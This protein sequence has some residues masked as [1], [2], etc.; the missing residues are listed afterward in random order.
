MKRKRDLQTYLSNLM[1][2]GMVG[3]PQPGNRFTD[4]VKPVVAFEDGGVVRFEVTPFLRR[5]DFEAEDGWT[6]NY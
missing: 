6:V 2:R 4:G 1:Q 5:D 3:E